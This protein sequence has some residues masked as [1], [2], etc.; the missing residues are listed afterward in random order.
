MANNMSKK[1][2]EDSEKQQQASGERQI[3]GEK[4]GGTPLTSILRNPRLTPV[5]L[6]ILAVTPLVIA[7]LVFGVIFI[8]HGRF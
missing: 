4:Y 7:A 1:S 2:V 3:F 8:S 5:I 6:F